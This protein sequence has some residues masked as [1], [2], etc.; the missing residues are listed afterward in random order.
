[1]LA[2]RRPK[3]IALLATIAVM[4]LFVTAVIIGQPRP[5]PHIVMA[6]TMAPAMPV[7]M[8]QEVATPLAVPPPPENRAYAPPREVAPPGEPVADDSAA[9][10]IKPVEVSLPKL[11]YAYTLGFRLEGSKI[12]EAQESHRA[13]CE[14]MGPAR[15]QVLAMQRGEAD[16]TQTTARLKLRVATAESRSFSEA[17]TRTVAKAGG[18]AIQTSVT[19]EDVSKQIVDAV[20]RIRQREMLVARLTEILRTR[21]GTVSELVEAERSVA[22]AQEELDQTRGW[23]TELRGRVAMSDFEISYNAVAP[24]ASPQVAKNQLGEA[25]WGSGMAF[26]IAIRTL[27]TMLIYLAPWLL[28]LVPVFYLVRRLKRDTPPVTLPDD[29]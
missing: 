28:L 23:L 22:A 6:D 13:L 4:A 18:R 24:K 1:M 3:L 7:S 21:R 17:L 19:T 20:A 14:R 2:L 9:A 15:C 10:D 25:T 27:L 11:A 5:Q 16:D 26:L 12:A 29:A 8:N